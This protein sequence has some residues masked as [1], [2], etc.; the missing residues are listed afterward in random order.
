MEITQK[1][2]D[3]AI[4][5]ELGRRLAQVRLDRN[6]T[7]GDLANAAGLSKRTVERSETG[8][9]IQLSS[10]IRL[11]RALGIAQNFDQLLPPL[12]ASPMEQL[13]LRGKERRR[14]SS[15]KQATQTPSEWSWGRD[16]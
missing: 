13:K 9:S 6:L 11:L 2:T 15:R 1:N 8:G 7:Q 4:L 3:T 5:E 12:L 14:A 10:F 16:K